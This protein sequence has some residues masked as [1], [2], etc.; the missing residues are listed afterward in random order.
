MIQ[1][2]LD[3]LTT[4]QEHILAELIEFAAIPSISTDPAHRADIDRAAAWVAGQIA[5]A[6]PFNVRIIPT[7]G[8]P[9]V[10]A[11]WLGA[12]GKPTILVYGHYDVQP[13]DPLEKWISPPF[14]PTIR[15][16]AAGAGLPT[17][18]PEGE[19]RLY[20]RGISDDKG[21]IFQAIKV[22]QAFFATQ[23]RLP[24]N[25]KFIF[26]G[27]EEIGSPS[28]EPFI[29]SHTDLLAADFVISADGGMWRIQEPSVTIS[30][31]GLAGLEFSLTGAAKDL[32]SGRHGGAVANPLHA[33]AELVAS[34]HTPDGR[35]AVAGFYA[36]VVELPAEERAAI[37]ALPFDAAEYLAEV[38]APA[39]VGEP[40]YSTLE[41]QW[42]R[43]TLEI[44]GLWGGYQGPGTKTVTPSEAH[45]KITCRLVPNQDPAD[46][47]AKITR[48]LE[49]HLPAGVRLAVTPEAHGAQPY[50]IPADH[51]GLRAAA[52]ALTQT[53]GSEPVTVRMGGTV[54]VCEVFKRVMGLDTVFFSFSTADE[55]F[56]A[57]NEF[58]RV[59]RLYEGLEGWARYWEVLGAE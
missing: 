2:T 56:H 52:A 53:F 59:Q 14:T 38:G 36:D 34:L 11:Q 17:V 37:A 31:R 54:P 41:R 5:A 21:P 42:T 32:H 47:A 45:A 18:P 50:R 9:V 40:G 24:V 30:S 58:F 7:G 15:T 46:I 39:L 29:A 20:A 57:P 44:N 19:A 48:H 13:P 49:A 12:A 4:Q 28:L 22:A 27:E 1:T 16:M 6:G 51:F 26:E 33:I 3:Y 35:V 43:P 8:H 23:G 10:F 55:D 25:V